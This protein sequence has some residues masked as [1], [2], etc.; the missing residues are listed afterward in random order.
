MLYWPVPI[1]LHRSKDGRDKGLTPTPLPQYL[2]IQRGSNYE[3]F[4]FTINYNKKLFLK[5]TQESQ[6]KFH[7]KHDILYT[8]IFLKF[9]NKNFNINDP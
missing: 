2:N 6:T 1:T 3:F 4:N 9:E 8:V 5:S 7:V